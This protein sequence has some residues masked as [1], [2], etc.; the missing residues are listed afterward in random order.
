MVD[1]FSRPLNPVSKIRDD[2]IRIIRVDVFDKLNP[3][4]S[5]SGIAFDLWGRLIK[6]EATPVDRRHYVAY[7]EITRE[8]FNQ[9]YWDNLW[10][11]YDGEG[12]G[13][14]AAY[15]ATLDISSFNPEAPPFKTPAFY[16]IADAARAPEIPEAMDVI[17]VLGNPA[18]FTLAQLRE[19]ATGE[20]KLWL[21]E[22][23]N[24]RS[25]PHRLE[26]CGYIPVRSD[27]KSGLWVIAGER[28]VVYA[29]RTLPLQDQIK[30]ARALTNEKVKR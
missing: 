28:Q 14:V 9:G 30:A 19:K 16:A 1:F 24:R 8:K 5:L 25:V 17:D 10:K 12:A 7:S 11:W 21:D 15:L 18:A 6:I 27:V 22:R 2:V 26:S 4:F 13:H 23:K 3:P 29:D 20:F